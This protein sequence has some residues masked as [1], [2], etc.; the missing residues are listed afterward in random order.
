MVQRENVVRLRNGRSRNNVDLDTP[1][2]TESINKFIHVI[3]VAQNLKLRFK[4]T[5]SRT[6]IS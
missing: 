5:T 6:T 3:I 2:R 1:F 4:T